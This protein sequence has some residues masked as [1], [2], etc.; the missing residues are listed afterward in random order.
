MRVLLVGLFA[1]LWMAMSGSFTLLNLGLGLAVAVAALFVVRRDIGSGPSAL[2]PLALVVLTTV[3]LKELGV[4]A[5]RVAAT[6]LSPRLDLKPGIL[7]VP[8]TVD[9]DGEIALLANL[10]TLTPGTLSV[11][12]S[13]DRGT[14][15]VHALDCSD[16][17][18]TRREI[19]EGFERLIKEAFR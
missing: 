11:D 8:L 9:R 10:I 16:P 13:K 6:V 1:V 7:A 19:A 4:S 18:A 14:L 17:G 3:F 2:R 5:W 15:Y 12:V